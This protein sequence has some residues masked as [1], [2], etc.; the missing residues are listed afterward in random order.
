M[1]IPRTNNKFYIE[2]DNIIQDNTIR[3]H[4]LLEEINKE[5][6][7]LPQ[8]YSQCDQM[9]QDLYYALDYNSK[10]NELLKQFY[11]SIYLTSIYLKSYPL[12][13]VSQL[14][15][16]ISINNSR[17]IEDKI[18]I[19]EKYI[20]LKNLLRTQFIFKQ[21]TTYK[22]IA[23]LTASIEAKLIKLTNNR[24]AFCDFTSI[25]IWSSTTFQH[26]TSLT[27][28]GINCLIQLNDERLAS[29]SK[30]ICLWN[31]K[32]LQCVGVSVDVDSTITSLIQIK[33]GNLASGTNSVSIIIWDLYTLEQ[34]ASFTEYDGSIYSIVQLNSEKI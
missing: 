21:I 9:R 6:C 33:N 7:Q 31:S 23:E 17:M 22:C 14:A 11:Q 8:N 4:K 12:Y 18:T 28:F 2:I 29:G 10:T 27:C 30:G 34:I 13:Q 32:A 1:I 26:L 19:E 24:F 16:A 15:N 5:M 20:E 25:Q 3:T